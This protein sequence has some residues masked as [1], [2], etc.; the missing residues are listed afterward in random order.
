M[1]LSNLAA[2]GSVGAAVR[3]RPLLD[4]G[5]EHARMLRGKLV[6]EH[7]AVGV[8]LEQAGFQPLSEARSRLYQ[9]RS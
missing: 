5:R 6:L 9:L 7:L 8:L 1:A 2:R 4:E 3:R